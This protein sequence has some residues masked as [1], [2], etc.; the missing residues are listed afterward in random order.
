LAAPIVGR[1]MLSRATGAFGVGLPA[2]AFLPAAGP[3]AP[4]SALRVRFL[5]VAPHRG[6]PLIVWSLTLLAIGLLVAWPACS[7]RFWC[8]LFTRLAISRAGRALFGRHFASSS[9][10]FLF[11][12]LPR[13]GLFFLF[14]LSVSAFGT[15][16]VAW[17]TLPGL[18]LLGVGLSVL[19][20]V[21]RCVAT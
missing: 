9:R 8:G 13:I 7:L 19:L 20:G 16:L 3:I 11:R 10:R 6:W 15:L 5:L 2:G 17:R 14:G 18:V 4:L 21:I 1:F 12:W